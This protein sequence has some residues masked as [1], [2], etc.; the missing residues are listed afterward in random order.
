MFNTTIVCIGVR[1][2]AYFSKDSQIALHKEPLSFFLS[3]LDI[4]ENASDLSSKE[5]TYK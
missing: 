1:D 4:I 3:I 5:S 2:N